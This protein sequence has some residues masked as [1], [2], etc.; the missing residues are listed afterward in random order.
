MCSSAL[1]AATPRIRPVVMYSGDESGPHLRL[2]LPELV[3][4]CSGNVALLVAV[5]H[6]FKS[7]TNP[8]LSSDSGEHSNLLDVSH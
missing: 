4:C 3:K 2:E 1:I 7:M 8:A 5:L 6:A